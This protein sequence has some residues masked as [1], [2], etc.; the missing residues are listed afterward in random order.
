MKI[1]NGIAVPTTSLEQKALQNLKY[2]ALE[3]DYIN[4]L[5]MPLADEN[6]CNGTPLFLDELCNIYNESKDS[7]G[8]ILDWEGRPDGVVEL[9]VQY[10]DGKEQDEVLG[11]PSNLHTLVAYYR[12]IGRYRKA[13]MVVKRYKKF[14]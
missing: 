5:Y 8:V 13:A 11:I 7:S 9:R 3:K 14:M 6:I 2:N 10:P 12:G 4:P 1:N